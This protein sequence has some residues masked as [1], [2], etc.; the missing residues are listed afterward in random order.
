MNMGWLRL[1]LC[2]YE[3]WWGWEW[4]V[5]GCHARRGGVNSQPRVFSWWPKKW[6]FFMYLLLALKRNRL[7]FVSV[8]FVH[9]SNCLSPVPRLF[10][11]YPGKRLASSRGDP[12]RRKD[13]KKVTV[14]IVLN[15]V[16]TRQNKVGE[17]VT[18]RPTLEVYIGGLGYMRKHVSYLE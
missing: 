10:S 7:W 2:D 4:E 5:W 15:L 8:H 9:V 11:L 14:I 6:I 12:G 17:F 18:S 16:K 13:L 3:F 1:G